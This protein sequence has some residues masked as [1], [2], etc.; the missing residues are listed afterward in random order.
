VLRLW[1]S[2]AMPLLRYIP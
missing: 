2:G 1:M